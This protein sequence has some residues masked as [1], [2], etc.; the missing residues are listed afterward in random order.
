MTRT[1]P[2]PF[3]GTLT[4]PPEPAR[5]LPVCQE[6]WNLP[7][8]PG[9]PATKWNRTWSCRALSWRSRRTFADVV[10]DVSALAGPVI[11]GRATKGTWAPVTSSL[12]KG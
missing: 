7:G 5:F 6:A 3:H 8:L 10:S 9:P 11:S 1:S 4:T 12:K 2:F